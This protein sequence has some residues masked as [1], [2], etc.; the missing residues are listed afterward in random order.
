LAVHGNRAPDDIVYRTEMV[1][2]DVMSDDHDEPRRTRLGLRGE[3]AAA[4][5]EA[6]AQRV[7]I[8]RRH[9][10]R[11]GGITAAVE[12]HRQARELERG[13]R[14]QRRAV[15]DEMRVDRIVGV[16]LDVAVLG[17][18]A[19]RG[20][21]RRMHARRGLGEHAVGDREH[22][23][24]AADHQRDQ[25]GCGQAH[26]RGPG[27][28]AASESQILQELL[29]TRRYP[30]RARL[31]FG[32]GDVSEKAPGRGGRL[33][34][35]EAAL[36]LEACFLCQV[37]ADLV[38][39]VAVGLRREEQRPLDHLAPLLPRHGFLLDQAAL[40]RSEHSRNRCRQSRPAAALD[41][42]LPPAGGGQPV[43]LRT[44]VS[45][46]DLPGCVDPTLALEPV[47]GRVERAVIDDQ[48]L[49]RACAEGDA[50]AVAVLRSPLQR[51]EDEQ[52]ERALEQI[53]FVT[54]LRHK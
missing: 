21:P 53:R 26:A 16:G 20:Q 50:D 39:E 51:A 45:I 24:V 18:P 48:D 30:D 32:Q 34:V 49:L 52:I 14:L 11:P 38:I 3:E 35:S 23:R 7:E 13:D 31:L 44:L 27:Q 4:L 6:D 25:D 8:I 10:A 40:G 2:P 46:A 9:D 12:R 19:D 54:R 43:V 41:C 1:L 29:E 17:D 47:Q 5:D 28:D 22:R 33:A 15:L 37:K 36:R 42:E